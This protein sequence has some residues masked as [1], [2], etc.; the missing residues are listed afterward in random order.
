MK[1]SESYFYT[2]RENVRDEDSVS[3]NLLVRAGMIKK[4]SA[5]VYMYLPLGYKVLNKITDIIREEINTTGCQELLMPALIPEEV[6]ISSGRRE[7]FGSSMF[8]LKD[9]FNKPFSLG[10]THEELFVAA[11]QMDIKSYKD[12]PFGLY[13]F[14]T[15][16]RDEPRARFGLIRVR[17]F[18]MKDSYTFDVNLEA[19]EISYMKQFNAYKSSFD[20]MD[21]NYAV[22]RADTGVMGG[23]LSEEF[24][25]ITEI[26][27]D[28]LVLCNHCDYASNLE[29]AECID[30]TVESSE[31]K[32]S[33][34]CV[35][36]PNAKTIEEVAAFFNKET[37]S[38][39]KTLIYKLDDFFVAALVRGDREVNETKLCKL[40]DA[41][42]IELAPAEDV[43][44]ITKA[45]V[46]FAGPIDLDIPIAM[47]YEVSHLVNFIVGANQTDYH[48]TNVNL[49]DFTVT[50]TSD[51]RETVA[52]DSCPHCGKPVYFK[53]GVE[54]GNTFNLGTKYAESLDLQYLD[55]NNQLQYVAMGSYGIGVGRC[56]AA[57]AEQNYD[58]KGLIFPMNVAPCEAT[59]VVINRKDEQQLKTAEDL[60]KKFKQA[61]I[62]VMLDDRD[63]RA[64]VKFNDM[65]LI[66]I[67]IRITVGK[68]IVDNQVEF[69]LRKDTETTLV[70]LD[71]IVDHTV[72]VIKS[73][74]K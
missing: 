30:Q 35:A 62:D 22:V 34:E 67:P 63:E 51:I 74:K 42:E 69:K 47:D 25:A 43:V 5:G 27:E 1:L 9:R 40:F 33:K 37:T 55:S 64:G 73:Q 72:A 8:T 13:Q 28:T 44:R 65:D 29:V 48:Y 24:Q 26:G 3:G 36:T 56:L 57:I 58:E 71:S 31:A 4:S 50:H 21:I 59:I 20:R 11:A 15:K 52:G 12:L 6:F 32:Q 38:F 16:F 14:Q 46:G 10:P 17:E 53:R 45:G 18:M 60:Y 39:V 66:G 23:L 61:G 68:T 49:E 41:N 7:H 54:I 2:L 70:S 19:S